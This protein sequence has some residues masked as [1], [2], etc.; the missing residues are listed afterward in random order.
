MKAWTSVFVDSVSRDLRDIAALVHWDIGMPEHR[1]GIESVPGPAANEGHGEVGWYVRST[2]LRTRVGRKHWG[3]TAASPVDDRR[4]RPARNN[5][6]RP[7][8]QPKYGLVS[9]GHVVEDNAE[10]SKSDVVLQSTI[11]RWQWRVFAD[12]RRSQ[13]VSRGCEQRIPA[14]HKY[15][16]CILAKSG[17][18]AVVDQKHTKTHQAHIS[19][20]AK[21]MYRNPQYNTVLAM[22]T[23]P[24]AKIP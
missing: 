24:V 4:H 3:W 20:M 17:S 21:E 13:Y 6:S 12:R 18:D 14:A 16:R 2:W 15:C 23:R 22:Q 8:W 5:S 19:K 11:W 1:D 7:C 10:H 9:A